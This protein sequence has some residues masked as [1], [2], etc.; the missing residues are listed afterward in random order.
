GESALMTAV[1]SGNVEAARVLLNHGAKVDAREEWHSQTALMWAV[2]EKHPD[3]VKE[4]IAHG[5]D[6]NA[7]SHVNEWDGQHTAEPREKWLPLGG[8]TPLLFAAREG[9][10]PCARILVDSGAKL[11]TTD[12]D[13]I[14]PVLMAAIN[15]HYDAAVYLL[16]KGANPSLA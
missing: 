2:S 16:E 14:S 7:A 12:P 13:G 9:C 11:D 5:A 8:L 1:R 15:G 4:L 3:M 10:V 6:I